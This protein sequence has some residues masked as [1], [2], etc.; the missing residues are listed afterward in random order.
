MAASVHESLLDPNRPFTHAQGLAAGLTSATLRGPRFRRIMHGVYIHARAP[1]RPFERVEAALLIHPDR[2]YASH[3]S[4]ARVYRLPVPERLSDEHVTVFHKQDRRSP[5]GVC[6]H[7]APP[8]G[9]VLLLHGIRVS[10]PDQLFLE[11]ATLVN[12]VEL[13]V[14]GDALVRQ[15]RVT[16]EQL[17]AAAAAWTGRGAVLARRAASYV[18]RDVDSPMETRLRML[19]VLA[20]L[21]EPQVN[22]KV[23]FADGRVRYRFDLSYPDLKIV[24]EYDG[25]QHRADLDQWDHDLDRDEWLA[26]EHWKFV[27]VVSRGIYREPERTIERVRKAIVSRGGRV[28]RRVRDDWKPFFPV[29]P[30]STPAASTPAA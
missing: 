10:A 24:V 9:R 2:A 28:P 22:F 30:A 25:R 13:V 1:H 12:L 23:C 17:V 6:P 29:A 4:A 16:P 18:R 14:I 3:T 27:K 7:L 5:R 11:M 21:P 20:G 8:S 19:I 26:D 15:A